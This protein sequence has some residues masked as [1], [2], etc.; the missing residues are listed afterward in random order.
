MVGTSSKFAKIEALL[1]AISS[2]CILI[3]SVAMVVLIVTFGWLV[4]GRYVMNVTPTWV[5]QLALLLICYIAFLGAAAGI[6]ENTHLGV[7]LF[8]DM[9][10]V[11][12][13]KIV[14][15][16]IDLMLAAFGAVMVIAG[17][18]LMKFGWDTLLPMLDIP[19]SFRTLAI[20]SCGGLILLF[21]GTR[22]ILRILTFSDWHP[23]V[24]ELET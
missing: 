20:T 22:A 19:E 17:V 14:M 6:K 10:P 8:R 4:F 1:D 7:T 13:Q 24:Q 11:P 5:E 16:I 3:A 9:L 15:I 2:L 23:V 12:A 21:A 18:T